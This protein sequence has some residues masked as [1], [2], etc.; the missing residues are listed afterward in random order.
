MDSNRTGPSAGQTNGGTVRGVDGSVF[1]RGARSVMFEGGRMRAMLGGFMLLAVSL[2]AGPPAAR[3]E[4]AGVAVSTQPWVWSFDKGR[5]LPA[6]L[7]VHRG[8]W[9]VRVDPS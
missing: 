8:S 1:C 2:I 9:E 4:S 3:A 5:R 7:V 6:G